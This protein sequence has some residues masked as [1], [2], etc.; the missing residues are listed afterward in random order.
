M[1]TPRQ[2][3]Q[4]KAVLVQQLRTIKGDI[5]LRKKTSN[6]FR[7]RS[8]GKQKI[9]V[10]S[11][12]QVINVDTKKEICEVEGM[13][14]YA[15][16]VQETLKYGYMPT[17]VPEL[18][19][20]TI[21]GAFTGIGIESSSFRYGLVHE[22]IEEA[23]VLLGN[24]EV[25]TCNKEKNKD[26]FF[27]FPNSY[28]TLGYAL[29]I[30]VKIVPVKKY[31]KVQHQKYSNAQEYFSAL[32]DVCKKR[33]VDFADGVIFNVNEMY[34]TTGKFVDHAPFT[35]KYTFMGIYYQSIRRKKEDYLAV[36]DYI[37][38]WDPDWFWCSKHF[39]MQNKLVRFLFGKFLLRSTAYWKIM[40]WNRKYQLTEKMGKW[41][42]KREYNE[43]V[44]QDVE[45]PIEHCMEFI[46]FFHK[47]VKIKPVW[48]C[49]LQTYNQKKIYPLYGMNPKKSYINFGFWDTVKV[50]ADTPV[51]FINKKIEKKVQELGGKK[52]LYSDVY[53]KKDVFW[54]LYNK[55]A[56]DALKKRYDPQGRLR[57]LYEKCVLK[58]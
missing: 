58:A 25:V 48:V 30:K 54:R 11:F 8:D 41:V 14:T 52:S 21:G 31:V 13:T 37:W 38:R 36:K 19:S 39:K 9:N 33:T 40:F 43:S 55:K 1:D 10:R 17:V 56:Y 12:N 18:K 26:L 24:G 47:E 4:K 29:K 44:I 53:Y 50:H 35:S 20:I 16:L 27:G 49:P 28:G 22:T 2:Y 32:A 42:G 51:G 46:D 3:E 7:S 45:I 34:L 23:E 5:R 57:N 15:G 6:L